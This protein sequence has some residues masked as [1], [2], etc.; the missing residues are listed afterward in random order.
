ML[1][2]Y[3]KP[4]IHVLVCNVLASWLLTFWSE[5]INNFHSFAHDGTSTAVQLISPYHPNQRPWEC[6]WLS[7]SFVPAA[8]H[9][10][11]A[12]DACAG[13][14]LMMEHEVKSLSYVEERLTVI[15]DNLVSHLTWST[16]GVCAK[17]LK[18]AIQDTIFWEIW[19][20]IFEYLFFSCRP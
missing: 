17:T 20:C 7:G 15:L 9:P 16:T 5:C 8:S 11:V 12:I 13:R 2:I 6:C 4:N 1:P 18:F 14:L 3:R 10:N 19:V